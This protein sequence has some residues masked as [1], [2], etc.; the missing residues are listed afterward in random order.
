MLQEK[1]V[2]KYQV[3]LYIYKKEIF[4]V[5]ESIVLGGLWV[6]RTATSSSSPA[7]STLERRGGIGESKQFELEEFEKKGN[8]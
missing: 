8:R 2:E 7:T 5:Q 4:R 1:N 3:K 6:I